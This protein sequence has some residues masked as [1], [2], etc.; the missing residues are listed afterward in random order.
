M[1][2]NYIKKLDIFVYAKIVEFYKLLKKSYT[3]YPQTKTQPFHILTTFYVEKCGNVD[4][5]SYLSPLI[6][7]NPPLN[8]NEKL[9][10]IMNLWKS[11]N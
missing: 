7:I 1:H 11:G 8:K 9:C 6:H 4:N 5:L 10:I 3:H 2:K